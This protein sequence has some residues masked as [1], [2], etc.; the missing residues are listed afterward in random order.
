MAKQQVSD[1][2]TMNY[3]H[4]YQER[5][6]EKC[7]CGRSRAAHEYA[8]LLNSLSA[9]RFESVVLLTRI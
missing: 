6:P 1:E 2:F 9:D 4:P 5:S 3:P 8:D 7:E